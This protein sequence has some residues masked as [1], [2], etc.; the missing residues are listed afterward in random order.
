MSEDEQP[1]IKGEVNSAE[2]IT[3]TKA[4]HR[5]SCT[6]SRGMRDIVGLYVAIDDLLHN[7]GDTRYDGASMYSEARREVEIVAAMLD[8]GM[9]R[10][11]GD[12]WEVARNAQFPVQDGWVAK[13]N[14]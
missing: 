7:Y 11:K 4:G 9:I 8:A 12:A 6:A 2:Y 1:V 10:R 14:E 3:T 13:W 5:V